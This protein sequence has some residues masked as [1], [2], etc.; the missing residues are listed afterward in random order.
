[1][2]FIGK[3]FVVFIFIMSI[4]F[5]TLSA[6]VYS[7]H[8]NWEEKASIAQKSLQEAQ[9]LAESKESEYNRL[10]SE[11]EAQKEASLQ[12]V[13]KLESE[14][15]VLAGRTTNLQRE[16]DDLRG[17]QAE[18]VAAVNA[19][20]MSNNKTT[21]ENTQLRSDIRVSMEKTDDAYN[22][23][24]AATDDL[25]QTQRELEIA[26]EQRQSLLG[27]VGTMT[28]V[29]REE[30]LD[31]N[32]SID[33]VTP[34]IDGVVQAVSRKGSQVLIQV[35]LGTDDGLK[36]KDTVEIFRGTKYLGRATILKSDPNSA[37]GRVD[38]RYQ[39]G[40]IQEADRVATR[41]KLG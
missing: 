33:D 25:H 29:M 36:E 35:S 18:A 4:I 28:A 17:G 27:Q 39:E 9:A 3:I 23:A 31:P 5:M 24:L 13:R 26:A 22:K 12:Q 40:R 8:R 21:E 20:Q 10:K 38:P 16:V 41:L 30:G 6:V 15:D 32:T 2:N 7:T 14:R 11:L 1:M 34:R 19:T 37:I